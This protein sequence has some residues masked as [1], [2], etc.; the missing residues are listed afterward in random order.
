M[1]EEEKLLWLERHVETNIKFVLRN[2]FFYL[3][4]GVGGRQ[5]SEE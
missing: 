2:V 4:D 1:T 5:S 3:F